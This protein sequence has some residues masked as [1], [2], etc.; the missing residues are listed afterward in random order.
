MIFTVSYTMPL[1]TETNKV[2]LPIV[3]SMRFQTESLI[4]LILFHVSPRIPVSRKAHADSFRFR[5]IAS[6]SLLCS[7][8]SSFVCRFGLAD[9]CLLDSI[10]SQ[11]S[12]TLHDV[13]RGQPIS[14]GLEAKFS[15]NVPKASP[16]L[17]SA[18]SRLSSSIPFVCSCFRCATGFS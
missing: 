10:I 8:T 6:T 13:P 17:S 11:G 14:E 7:S 18:A 3:K 9:H 5:S 16:R 4:W 2:L 15:F 12:D 1:N